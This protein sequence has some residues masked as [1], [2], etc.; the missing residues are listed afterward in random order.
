MDD[1]YIP[2][3][4]DSDDA[5]I[6]KRS[7]ISDEGV[8]KNTRVGD[9]FTSSQYGNNFENHGYGMHANLHKNHAEAQQASEPSSLVKVNFDRFVVL[10]ASRSFMEV[11]E[12]NK[13]EEVVISTNLLTDLANAKRSAP[14]TKMPLIF[15][16]ALSLGIL[17]G[18]I[19]FHV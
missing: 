6:L 2:D 8:Y 13:D 1:I 3:E 10:V 12:R 11:V 5:M 14:E 19:F 9:D 16:G 4:D 7:K 15:I 18:Y 17:L